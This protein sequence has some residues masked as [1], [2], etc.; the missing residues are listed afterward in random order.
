MVTNS[1]NEV[2][3]KL[4]GF[5]V[6]RGDGQ[7]FLIGVA[8][9]ELPEIEPMKETVS[10]SGIAGEF[11]SPVMGHT[12]SLSCKL[13][14]R[15]LTS[16]AVSLNRHESHHL[17]FAGS[18]QS[19]D[20]ASGQ[21]VPKALRVVV[22]SLPLKGGLGKLETGKMM[23]VEHEL[24]CIYLKCFLDEQAVLEIDKLNCK[25]VVDGED[26]LALVRQHL[27]MES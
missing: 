1:I 12:G 24:E 5:R 20:G 6:Y 11:E 14:F 8:D 10:G 4:I 23:D 26:Q 22:K 25:Y 18:I 3:E 16:N 19:L 2:P 21:Y 13:K 9:C 17:T 7:T 15:T 27:L